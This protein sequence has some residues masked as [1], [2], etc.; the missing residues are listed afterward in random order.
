MEAGAGASQLVGSDLPA[1]L[2]GPQMITQA[3]AAVQAGVMWVIVRLQLTAGKVSVPLMSACT[4]SG[5][6]CVTAL[7]IGTKSTIP[8]PPATLLLPPSDLSAACMPLICWHA[9]CSAAACTG[10]PV[11]R[12][13]ATNPLAC[14]SCTPV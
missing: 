1:G 13:Y 7:Q 3:R 10:Q 9:P 5:C 12:W 11:R 8:W 6:A 4:N 14:L 2:A